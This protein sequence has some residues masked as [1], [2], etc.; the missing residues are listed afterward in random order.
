MGIVITRSIV[1][2]ESEIRLIASRSRGPG[3][4]HVNK[5]ST[6]MVLEFDLQQSTALPD[7]YKQRAVTFLGHRINQQGTLRLEAQR[8]RSQTANKRE[9]VEKFVCL[10][11]DAFRPTKVRRPTRVPA[12]IQE[13]RLSEKKQRGQIKGVRKRVQPNDE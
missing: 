2:P 5:V 12:R 4:Q 11:Q 8:H 3:G 9:V 10:L 7:R 13:K 6:G 1:I